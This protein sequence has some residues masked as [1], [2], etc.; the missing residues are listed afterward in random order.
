M[1]EGDLDPKYLSPRSPRGRLLRSPNTL[2]PDAAKRVGSL[3]RRIGES[4]PNKRRSSPSAQTSTRGGA[5]SSSRTAA[6]LSPSSVALARSPRHFDIYSDAD[7]GGGDGEHLAEDGELEVQGIG[8]TDE[9]LEQPFGDG[10]VA[11]ISNILSNSPLLRTEMQEERRREDEEMEDLERRREDE[12]D[13]NTE[14]PESDDGRRDAGRLIRDRD[15]EMLDAES[16]AGLEPE[17][18]DD[19]SRSR[20]SVSRRRVSSPKGHA[21]LHDPEPRHRAPD[22]KNSEGTPML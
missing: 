14:D 11:Q 6:L 8:T 5:S 4:S 16:S 3:K 10:V 19:L 1:D 15:A 18:L 17:D 22:R 9:F 21:S 12:Q 20:K 13:G 2:E 7:V